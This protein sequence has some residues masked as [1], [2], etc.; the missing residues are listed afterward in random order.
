MRMGW[1]LVDENEAAAHGEQAAPMKKIRQSEERPADRLI[2]KLGSLAAGCETA[3]GTEARA[4]KARSRR[5]AT[6]F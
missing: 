4:E 2:F 5:E 6:M 1:S 3:R